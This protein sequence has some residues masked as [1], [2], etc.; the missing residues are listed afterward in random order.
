VFTNQGGDGESESIVRLG[1]L[2]S[3][4][5][6]VKTGIYSVRI[7][8]GKLFKKFQTLEKIVVLEVRNLERV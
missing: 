4:E 5:M 1:N 6:R 8:R 2:L 3:W 7:G